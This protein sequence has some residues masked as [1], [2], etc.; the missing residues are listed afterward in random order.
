MA[1]FFKSGAD[2]FDRNSMKLDGTF[3]FNHD[4]Q[5]VWDILMSTQAIANALPGVE[6]LIPIENEVDSWRANAKISIASVSG[7]YAGIVRMSEK[8]PPH[9]YRLSVSGE[10][11][12]SIINGSALIT[13]AYDEQTRQTLLT[14]EAES[15]ISGKLAR[16]GQRVIK[17]AA[18]LLSNRFFQGVANQIKPVKPS[19]TGS[20]EEV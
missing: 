14:W 17:P 19:A 6:A 12:Q 7:S 3:T 18:T 4:Q 1:G 15:D 16:V 2:S 11:Q 5:T 10:G 8:N 9:R 13:L 20:R